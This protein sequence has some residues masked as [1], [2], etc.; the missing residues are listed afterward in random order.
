MISQ[1]LIIANPPAP[2]SIR[3]HPE[4]QTCP[5]FVP[6]I[7]FRGS[8]QGDPIKCVKKLSD[9]TEK[10]SGQVFHFF[11]KHLTNLGPLDWNPENNRREILD[12]FGVRGILNAE[13]RHLLTVNESPP[14]SANLKESIKILKRGMHLPSLGPHHP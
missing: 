14:S 7:V 9:K 10:V 11:E 2:Y 5:K 4:P 3:K 1:Y 13:G 8:N 12:K 6:T